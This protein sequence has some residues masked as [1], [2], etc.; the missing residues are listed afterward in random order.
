MNLTLVRINKYALMVENLAL[1][2][3]APIKNS[4][5][6]LSYKAHMLRIE[7]NRGLVVNCFA[8]SSEIRSVSAVK[9][10]CMQLTA[11]QSKTIKA[12]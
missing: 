5:P 8:E 11:N 10:I 2:L 7:F 9:S 4:A 1:L 6:I 3:K 12:R